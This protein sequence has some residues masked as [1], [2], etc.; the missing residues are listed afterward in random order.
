MV[1]D[2]RKK[3][4]CLYYSF[5]DKTLG[6]TCDSDCDDAC[7]GQLFNSVFVAKDKF[8]GGSFDNFNYEIPAVLPSREDRLKR[9]LSSASY[10]RFLLDSASLKDL[11]AESFIIEVFN[12]YIGCAVSSS[13][14]NG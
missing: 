8:G 5:L 12:E 1:E 14:A 4:Q 2:I 11:T 3:F 6:E 7:A 9:L 10:G 13:E